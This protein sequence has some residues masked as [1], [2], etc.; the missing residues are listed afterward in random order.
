MHSAGM[1]YVDVEQASTWRVELQNVVGRIL[2]AKLPIRSQVE[3]Y[4]I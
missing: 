1:W 4:K 3:D 2:S